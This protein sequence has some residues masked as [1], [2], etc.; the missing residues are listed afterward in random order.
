MEGYP[1]GN[2]QTPTPMGLY[3]VWQCNHLCNRFSS[4]P[5]H[6][7]QQDPILGERLS[8]WLSIWFAGLERGFGIGAIVW[9][10][11]S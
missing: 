6:P 1:L 11:S 9:F 4:D 8:P 5:S 2:F 10:W 7:A 3:V